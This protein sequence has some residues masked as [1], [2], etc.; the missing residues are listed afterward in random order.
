MRWENEAKAAL[1]RRGYE[2]VDQA[3]SNGYDGYGTLLGRAGRVYAVIDWFYGSCG[4][5]DRYEDLS[6]DDRALAF[7]VL[8]E[9]GM[10]EADARARFEE[11]KS[12]GW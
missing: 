11:H 1:G 10:S 5:C 2:V 9:D 12:R 4:V 8:V 6:D 7:D 3:G